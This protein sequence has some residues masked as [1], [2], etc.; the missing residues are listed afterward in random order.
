MIDRRLYLSMADAAD[1]HGVCQ[2]AKDKAEAMRERLRRMRV[3]VDHFGK[4]PVVLVTSLDNAMKA[5][6]NLRRVS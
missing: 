6:T 5:Q 3:P 2:T 1:R 4:T